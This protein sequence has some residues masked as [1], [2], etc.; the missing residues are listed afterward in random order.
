MNNEVYDDIAGVQNLIDKYA[1]RSDFSHSNALKW[2][3]NVHPFSKISQSYLFSNEN[4]SSYY[5]LFNM[6]SKPVLTVTGSGDQVLSAILYGSNKVDTFDSNKLAYYNLMLKKYA[7]IS[8]NY[9][10]F[11][12][13]YCL[14]EGNNKSAIYNYFSQNIKENDVKIFWDAF[15][16]HNSENFNCCFLGSRSLVNL[17]EKRIPYMN[18]TNY[19]ILSEKLLNSEIN[20][21]NIDMFDITNEFNDKYGFINLSNILQYITDK[22][23]FIKMINML[24]TD[25]LLENSSILLNY[26]WTDMFICNDFFNKEIYEFFGVDSLLIDDLAINGIKKEAGKIAVYTKKSK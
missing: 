26:Y 21:K 5:N 20:Y 18:D 17:V 12:N 19:K 2:A 25:F 15:F 7:I 22:K 4:L 16:S 3:K 14:N 13:F 9:N 6:D 1:Y 23:R 11:K 8:L 24:S 10:D